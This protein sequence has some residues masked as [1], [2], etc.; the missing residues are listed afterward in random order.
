MQLLFGQQPVDIGHDKKVGRSQK[1]K[2]Q[3]PMF[4]Y[5]LTAFFS[6]NL[7]GR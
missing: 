2:A 1:L 7:N 4:Q 5:S 6:Q 3:S